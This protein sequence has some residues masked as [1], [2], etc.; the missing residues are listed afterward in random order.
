MVGVNILVSVDSSFMMD[1]F[2]LRVLTWRL[3]YGP[4][5]TSTPIVPSKVSI[6]SHSVGVGIAVTSCTRTDT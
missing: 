6:V 1:R 2:T 4:P 3:L 5:S